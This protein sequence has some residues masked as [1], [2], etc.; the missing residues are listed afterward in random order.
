M[1]QVNF[2]SNRADLHNHTTASDG[3]LR[4]RAL[5]EYAYMKGLKA[6]A[7]TDHDTT[8]GIEEAVKAGKELGIEIIPGIEINTQIDNEEIHILGY[9]IEANHQWLQEILYK[10]RYSRLNR[11]RI[12]VQNLCSIYGINI[13]YMEVLEQAKEGAVAR[14]HIARVLIEKG[15]VA[16]LAEAFSKYLG[17]NCPAYA[18]RYRLTPKEGIDLI[19]KA[20]GIAVLAHPG[21]LNKQSLVHQLIEEGVKGIEAYHSKHTEEQAMYY[22]GLALKHG[23]I[24]TGGSDCHGELMDG[25]PIIGD[26]TVGLEVV[27]ALRALALNNRNE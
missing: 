15:I 8:D 4:P 13:N 23:L 21:L 14:P 25:M 16:D 6:I 7:V 11:A 9:Y 12:M 17:T 10:I 22:K 20:G 2:S 3:L 18:D 24:A 1:Q 27:E 26:V 5:V 19:E